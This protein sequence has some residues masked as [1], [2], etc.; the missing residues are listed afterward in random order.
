ME[1]T[2]ELVL[3]RQ[4]STLTNKTEIFSWNNEQTYI[5]TL[6]LKANINSKIIETLNNFSETKELSGKIISI[7]NIN[8]I[9]LFNVNKA[10]LGSGFFSGLSFFV[11][12]ENN[13]FTFKSAF[14]DIIS[15]KSSLLSKLDTF[16]YT[17]PDIN[18]IDKDTLLSINDTFLNQV[19]T[20]FSNKIDYDLTCFVLDLFLVSDKM[21]TLFLSFNKILQE[22]ISTFNPA[23][24][25][26][27]LYFI[28]AF[29]CITKLEGISIIN[30]GYSQLFLQK[31]VNK[32]SQFEVLFLD[33]QRNINGILTI[34]TINMDSSQLKLEITSSILDN[35]NISKKTVEDFYS[36]TK[37]LLNEQEAAFNLK[38]NSIV[39]M[40]QQNLGALQKD[41]LKL[42]EERENLVRESEKALDISEKTIEEL[43]VNLNKLTEPL[44]ITNQQKIIVTGVSLV[45]GFLLYKGVIWL[46]TPRAGFVGLLNTFLYG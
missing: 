45:S 12:S 17:L 7:I 35:R 24:E 15:L 38:I 43:R 29:Y 33:W 22:V 10:I 25:I 6:E 23:T 27:L 11:I 30:Q 14:T 34:N 31:L 4:S 1:G 39:E 21:E 13:E 5:T 18:K 8:E 26:S 19:I 46:S 44:S 16:L 37:L 28:Y 40:F 2:R 36:K 9:A 41:L 32:I 42:K 20:S 3:S